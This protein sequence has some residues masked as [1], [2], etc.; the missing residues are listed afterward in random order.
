VGTTKTEAP[1]IRFE[2]VIFVAVAGSA[3]HRRGARDGACVSHP[4][5]EP[6]VVTSGAVM[7]G[8]A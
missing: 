8:R 7:F 5:D 3:P 6:V 4:T 1:Y 2:L